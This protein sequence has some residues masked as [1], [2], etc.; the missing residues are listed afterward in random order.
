M[1]EGEENRGDAE[2]READSVV[3]NVRPGL[4]RDSATASVCNLCSACFGLSYWVKRQ[5]TFVVTVD[6]DR[7]EQSSI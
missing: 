6:V 2:G 5:S 1:S 3:A 7:R 4:F